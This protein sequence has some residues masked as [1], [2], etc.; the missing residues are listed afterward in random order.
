MHVQPY[1][2]GWVLGYGRGGRANVYGTDGEL[3]RTMKIGDAV[4]D[5][6]TLSDGRIWVSYFDEGVYGSG[7]STQGL[8]CFDRAGKAIFKFREYA[9]KPKLPPIDDCYAMNVTG[10]GDV[11]VNYYMA[12]PLVLLREME[13]SQHWLEFGSMGNAFAVRGDHVIYLRDSKLMTRRL[14]PMS[15]PE[16]MDAVDASGNRLSPCATR[17]LSGAARGS[18][19]V[20]NTG[21][22]IYVAAP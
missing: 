13:A 15:E 9:D 16:N 6:Q 19:L 12:F 21:T 22:A 17:Y 10:H 8:V 2:S 14:E 11:W 7:I 4:E 5:L 1:D 18:S 3:L 20:L